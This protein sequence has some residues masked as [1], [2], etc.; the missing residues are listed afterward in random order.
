MRGFSI[1]V[2][3]ALS[4]LPQR[5]ASAE[6]KGK[7]ASKGQS[8]MV[9]IFFYDAR[10]EVLDLVEMFDKYR[11]RGVVGIRAVLP[12]KS[13]GLND[14]LN[15]DDLRQLGE[16]HKWELASNGYTFL[17]F[18]DSWMDLALELIYSKKLIEDS[19]GIPVHT[20][21]SPTGKYPGFTDFM[22]RKLYGAAL[23]R[24]EGLN[25]PGDDRFRLKVK[26]L[27]SGKDEMEK[28]VSALADSGLWAI[29]R[30]DDPAGARKNIEE[31]LKSC[32]KH[33]VKVVTIREGTGKLWGAPSGYE[34]ELTWLF[35]ASAPQDYAGEGAKFEK[36]QKGL[37]SGWNVYST[38]DSLWPDTVREGFG[39]DVPT[40]THLRAYLTPGDTLILTHYFA[41]PPMP[42]ALFRIYISMWSC[43]KMGNTHWTLKDIEKDLWWDNKKKKWAPEVIRNT[44][45]VILIGGLKPYST[46]IYFPNSTS[47]ELRIFSYDNLKR[48]MVFMYDDFTLLPTLKADSRKLKK[49]S[50][51]MKQLTLPF[52]EI[53]GPVVSDEKGK[54]YRLEVSM[55]GKLKAVPLKL[56]QS[57]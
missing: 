50:R 30:V 4:V 6:K 52:S 9:S 32:R 40:L 1:L 10:K 17:G 8:G 14:V 38:A 48:D 18:Y 35:S 45:D 47:L 7:S 34:K 57:K 43:E 39:I 36:W 19:T 2:F 49:L 21:V 12:S 13:K 27:P 37:P 22:V 55:E 41:V 28:V 51:G 44:F 42:L 25:G 33:G 31:L 5:G 23:S 54:L 20:Y 11:A 53:S 29:F 26:K 46:Y 24:E 15:F 16:G 3:I 56:R